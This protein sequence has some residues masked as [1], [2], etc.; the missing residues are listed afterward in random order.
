MDG[1]RENTG[2]HAGTFGIHAGGGY[3]DG[4]T[5]FACIVTNE[6]QAAVRNWTWSD[7]GSVLWIIE[8]PNVYT[9][10]YAV[11]VLGHEEGA[12]IFEGKDY[13]AGQSFIS[14]EFLTAA[15]VEAKAFEGYTAEVVVD[16]ENGKIIVT[17][18]ADEAT[19]VSSISTSQEPSTI[20]D[21]SGRRVRKAAKGVY[22]VDGKKVIN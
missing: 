22:I 2:D 7:H 18:T 15:D 5:N 11:E 17:Y 13:A 10:E 16:K 1:I 6:A 9:L 19:G 3:S 20:Y 8:N 4:S 12:V 21:L 14:T